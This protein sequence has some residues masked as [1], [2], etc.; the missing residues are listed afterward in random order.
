ML[1]PPNLINISPTSNANYSLISYDTNGC[2][3]TDSV[4]VKVNPIPSLTIYGPDT[5]CQDSIAIFQALTS[6]S[7]FFGI[8]MTPHQL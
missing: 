8:P 7:S 3:Y 2:Q 6:A 4:L 5:I 1:I